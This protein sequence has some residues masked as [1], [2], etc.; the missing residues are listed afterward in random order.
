MEK[1]VSIVFSVPQNFDITKLVNWINDH[2]NLNILNRELGL[3]NGNS[4][5]A[6]SYLDLNHGE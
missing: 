4:P 5:I 3:G 6:I 2:Y 1:K